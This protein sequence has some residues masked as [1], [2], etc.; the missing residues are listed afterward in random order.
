MNIPISSF[1]M[2]K[3]SISTQFILDQGENFRVWYF[4]RILTCLKHVSWRVSLFYIISLLLNN[5]KLK[6]KQFP[7]LLTFAPSPTIINHISIMKDKNL[8]SCK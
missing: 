7:I 6:L 8:F 1:D 5:V 3:K 4:Q 2:D